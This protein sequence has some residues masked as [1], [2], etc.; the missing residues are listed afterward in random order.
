M[1]LLFIMIISIVS[2][3]FAS[4]KKIAMVDNSYI[5]LN[6]VYQKMSVNYFSK[7]LDDII[8]EKLLLNYAKKNNIKA[9]KRE[10]D[11]MIFSIKSRFNSE[12]DFKKELDRMGLNEKN[13]RNII[14]NE[15][16][17]SKAFDKILNINITDEDAKKYYDLNPE[18][19]KIPQ[20]VKLR[21][22]F[23]NTEQEA[24]DVY[25]ALQA[26]ADFEKIA[27]LKSVDENL[28]K[29]G[30][31]IGYIPKG[32]IVPDI[33]KEVFSL[34]ISKY[35]K[36]LRTGN[37]YS[38]IKV[39]D[40]K[41]EQIIPFEQAKEKIKEYIKLQIINQNKTTVINKLKENSKITLF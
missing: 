22:I 30:G 14:E 13:Y 15:I 23:V 12:S 16:T 21:Q 41:A 37:G 38:I 36:P 4:D 35:T 6:D 18:Q 27:L 34:E 9:E 26:G 11:E 7:T 10:I 5:T 31:D 39:E 19:F 28:K 8:S 3:T 20:T 29:N 33:E 2:S 32:M 1:N 25:I 17:A 40:K 24:N